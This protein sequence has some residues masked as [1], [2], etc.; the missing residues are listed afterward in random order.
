MH[1]I[2]CMSTN[3][4]EA[5]PPAWLKTRAQGLRHL[6]ISMTALQISN[7]S[8]KAA[9][10][11]TFESPVDADVS[12][13]VGL[14]LP[15]LLQHHPHDPP[16]L[17]LKGCSLARDI[18]RQYR[19]LASLKDITCLFLEKARDR[20]KPLEELCFCERLVLSDLQHVK[21]VDVVAKLDRQV[22]ESES[23]GGVG[24]QKCSNELVRLAG[25]AFARVA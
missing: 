2:W 21:G 3:L 6:P 15:R 23:D 14:R 1:L 11:S 19:V 9:A 4:Q 17:P 16:N 22:E 10:Q 8:V 5:V 12:R 25:M 20:L 13:L 24:F 18:A 7:R